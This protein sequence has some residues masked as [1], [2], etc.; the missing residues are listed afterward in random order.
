MFLEEE[1]LYFNL[2]KYIYIY[3]KVV[4]KFSKIW[5]ATYNYIKLIERFSL[6]YGYIL[7][8]F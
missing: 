3:T 5:G 8:I 6:H 4:Y 1:T 7:M 2:F